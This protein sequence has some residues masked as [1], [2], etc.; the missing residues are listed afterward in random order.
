MSTSCA[1]INCKR[2]SRALCHC[3]QQNLCI[4]H[5]TEH[6]DLL[7]SQLHPLTDEVNTLG[8]RFKTINIEYVLGDC[9]QKLE[10]WRQVCHTKIDHFVDQKLQEID[11][12]ITKKLDGQQKEITH[13]QSKLAKIID[14]QAATQE[15]IDTLT[16]TIRQ[17]EKQINKIEET[18]FMIDIRPLLIDDNIVQVK[19]VCTRKFDLSMCSSI[20]KT[21]TYPIGSRRSLASNGRLLLMHQEPNLCFVNLEL[22]IIKQMLWPHDRIN[23]MCWSSILDRFIVTVKD[24]IFLVDENLM[25]IENVPAVERRSWLSCTSC[26]DRLF[27]T[28]QERG[29]PIIEISLLPS[30]AVIKEWKSPRSCKMDESIHD[31]VYNNGTL[32]VVLR[33]KAE[34][35]IRMELRSCTTLDCL[36][37]LTLD[38]VL[39]EIKFRCCSL[40]CDEWLMA[41]Y[42]AG[43]LLH[44]TADGKVKETIPYKE[45][46]YYITLFGSNMLA[47]ATEK[48]INF[49]KI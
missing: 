2:I 45:T 39:K 44:I 38:V 27:L 3:C 1:D 18:R 40:T 28:T 8:E 29:S 10:Q 37:S 23:Y 25:S 19:D 26:N 32:A 4:I 15:D 41:D 30:L 14:D 46:P 22:T 36:W 31:M 6:N 24:D 5:L 47:I 17:L 42:N 9:R 33:K 11:L 12:L 49:H 16:S 20:C 13:L 43:R 48:G 35:S 7:N 21:I 34:K